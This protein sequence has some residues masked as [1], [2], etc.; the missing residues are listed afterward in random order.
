MLSPFGTVK[1]LAIIVAFGLALAAADELAQAERHE[2]RWPS[3][4]LAE[5]SGS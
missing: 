4:A 3:Y 5:P 1:A 2:V